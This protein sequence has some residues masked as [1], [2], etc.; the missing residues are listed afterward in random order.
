M[1]TQDAK[2][3]APL[4]GLGLA[5]ALAGLALF[6][7]VIAWQGVGQVL[8]ALAVAGPGLLLVAAFHAA[9]LVTNAIGW[10]RLLPADGPGLA[11]VTRARWVGE[12]VNGLLPVAQIGGNVARATMLARRG[13]PA[14]TAGASVVVD[15]TMNVVAQIAF[16][17]CGLGVLLATVGARLAVPVLIGTAV[18]SALLLGFYL[19]Q[20]RGLFGGGARVLDRL[21]RR[22][23]RGDFARGAAAL[24]SEVQRLYGDR[25]A[26]RVTAA[27]HFVSWVLGAGEV[28]LG[29]YWLGH[30]VGPVT[31]L[32]IES[33]GQALRS[34]AFLVPGALGIQEG[35]YLLL[36]AAFGLDPATALALSL[37]KRTREVLLGVPGLAMWLLEES[38]V[39]LPEPR[40]A[41]DDVGV[42]EGRR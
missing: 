30:P 24:D 37:V 42:D 21:S 14:G 35:G 6:V 3:R 25:A 26:L 40:A 17:L 12:S 13:V 1:R 28:W 41:A 19:S 16:T 27:W 8:A 5:G 11:A 18:M 23:A 38:A 39:R 33:L 4:G 29:L 10:R 2:R 36:G 32:L 34:A 20:R 31:A 9:P 22:V 7:G 15:I